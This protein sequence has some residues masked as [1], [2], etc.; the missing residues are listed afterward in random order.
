M[1]TTDNICNL[2]S[3]LNKYETKVAKRCTASH[4][5]KAEE[6]FGLRLMLAL[7][8]A[9]YMSGGYILLEGGR[10]MGVFINEGLWMPEDSCID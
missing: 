8:V 3:L 6:I 5:R 2:E 1:T 9:G 4:R 10:F 7:S